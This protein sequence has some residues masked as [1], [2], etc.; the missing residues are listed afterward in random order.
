M[1]GHIARFNGSNIRERC[2]MNSE[3]VQDVVE[4]L[5]E[6][7]AT[8]LEI[9]TDK[10]SE[11]VN[12]IFTFG[13]S[14][15]QTAGLIQTMTAFLTKN[16]LLGRCW[17]SIEWLKEGQEPHAQMALKTCDA[18]N[19]AEGIMQLARASKCLASPVRKVVAI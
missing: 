13:K 12:V 3:K 8:P 1:A 15:T 2:S 18:R 10:V 17:L 9:T 7:G 16:G 19:V 14:W 5:K 11:F 6:M 4:A